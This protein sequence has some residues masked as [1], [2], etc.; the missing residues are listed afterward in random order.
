MKQQLSLDNAHLQEDGSAKRVE[1]AVVFDGVAANRCGNCLAGMA[2]DNACG[3]D[4]W[5]AATKSAVV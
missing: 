4:A 2:S 5:K 3:R 1:A